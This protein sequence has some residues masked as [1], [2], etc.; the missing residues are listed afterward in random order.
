MER[1]NSSLNFQNI[2]LLLGERS[3]SRH[4]C[5]NINNES[6][7]FYD[8]EKI[9][10]EFLKQLGGGSVTT[11]LNE[12]EEELAQ[13]K[14]QKIY[15]TVTINSS[16]DPRKIGIIYS[17]ALPG[18]SK[19][20]WQLLPKTPPSIPLIQR[21]SSI[22]SP[23]ERPPTPPRIRKQG[24]LTALPVL[25][26][27]PA[28]DPASTLSQN[29]EL[30]SLS[31]D[32]LEKQ[33]SNDSVVERAL[34]EIYNPS[35]L[36]TKI[37]EDDGFTRSL[38]GTSFPPPPVQVLPE[39]E[40]ASLQEE[41]SSTLPDLPK[42]TPSKKYNRCRRTSFQ[43]A[44]QKAQ[45]L[46]EETPSSE[47][48]ERLKREIINDPNYEGLLDVDYEDLPA[49]L[50][51]E[52]LYKPQKFCKQFSY[53]V[54]PS[55]EENKD[56]P[57]STSSSSTNSP[58]K[59]V[60]SFR[61]QATK[62]LNH[63]RER[64]NSHQADSG[65]LSKIEASFFQDSYS[66]PKSEL[67]L[68]EGTYGDFQLLLEGGSDSKTPT[69]KNL[70]RLKE[71]LKLRFTEHLLNFSTETKYLPGKVQ[72]ELCQLKSLFDRLA[73]LSNIHS[74]GNKKLLNKLLDARVATEALIAYLYKLNDQIALNKD[75]VDAIKNQ[76]AI[77]LKKLRKE[78]S[79]EN[80]YQL[81]FRRR[82]FFSLD[83]PRKQILDHYNDHEAQ[84]LTTE[85]GAIQYLAQHLAYKAFPTSCRIV[86]NIKQ[87]KLVRF[88]IQNRLQLDQKLSHV[89]ISELELE[90]I[91][92]YQYAKSYKLIGMWTDEVGFWAYGLEPL[93]DKQD[94]EKPY[95]SILVFR[96]TAPGLIGRSTTGLTA[97]FRNQF[98][99]MSILD[100][101]NTGLHDWADEQHALVLA[102]HSL[103]GATA[104]Q[105]AA[106]KGGKNL[107]GVFT[108][109]SPLVAKDTQIDF[110]HSFYQVRRK[111]KASLE[112]YILHYVTP[113]DIIT[114]AGGHNEPFGPTGRPIDTNNLA[115]RVIIQHKTIIPG[116]SKKGLKAAHSNRAFSDAQI[117]KKDSSIS[118]KS[119]PE[120]RTKKFK[121][122]N[123]M[124]SR[125]KHDF[126]SKV[127]I[128][129]ISEL[130][131]KWRDRKIERSEL[132]SFWTFSRKRIDPKK[133]EGADSLRSSLLRRN[134]GS[135][136][137]L[138]KLV[139]PPQD[140]PMH[141]A[142]S[143]AGYVIDDIKYYSNGGFESLAYL[144]LME[145]NKIITKENVPKKAEELR[146]LCAAFIRKNLKQAL[147]QESSLDHKACL[148]CLTHQ[149]KRAL[150]L[151]DSMKLNACH[152]E[153]YLLEHQKS[154]VGLEISHA[155]TMTHCD[156]LGVSERYKRPVWLYYYNDEKEGYVEKG[157]IIPSKVI[158]ANQED[159]KNEP[160]RLFCA[161]SHLD[162]YSPIAKTNS[163]VN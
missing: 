137:D 85:N 19:Y 156:L 60:P 144:L 142:L 51:V 81:Y 36:K 139:R 130:F 18:T 5:L 30:R 21:N 119:V 154:A 69:R 93:I 50:L 88:N 127:P 109:S 84:H 128:G 8:A 111:G 134:T 143:E 58:L 22:D 120:Y 62:I 24:T 91:P 6:V 28:V 159:A 23:A 9:F 38:P 33:G 25:P 108:F 43:L 103:G 110:A 157:E 55:E 106:A 97:D 161:G 54:T 135:K 3:Y 77:N 64:E 121:V 117:K 149:V 53:K 27:E 162:Y 153:S 95:C 57:P 122:L 102:G 65:P 141:E 98:A 68:I 26:I 94:D 105:Y 71:L 44:Q 152:Y 31:G 101:K 96:G 41:E 42:L 13:S 49:A 124:I 133:G 75:A 151:K 39:N 61:R 40:E 83:Y 1:A 107:V 16:R 99:K 80:I 86:E 47:E 78:P 150:N 63:I 7:P 11:S 59:K 125:A 114:L 148:D 29:S 100:I 72:L 113:K 10:K 46:L 118:S 140:Y 115:A 12:L 136:T 15:K 79:H 116:I 32:V 138:N 76:A 129:P 4:I 126:S 89:P 37:R 45:V 131:A 87:W 17:Q 146:S 147:N 112:P 145:E 155:K 123:V 90:S 92:N 20:S 56:S 67:E 74:Q 160:L 73:E 66:I 34:D 82:K 104:Q 158:L 163:T 14:K 2:N 70:H 35:F 52:L 48:N 132:K